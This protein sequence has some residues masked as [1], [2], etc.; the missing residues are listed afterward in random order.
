MDPAIL[1]HYHIFKNAGTSV[2]A[3]LRRHFGNRWAAFEGAHAHDVKSSSELRAFLDANP[4]VRAVSSHLARPPLPT[5]GSVPIVFLRHPLLRARSV[6]EFTR[7]DAAQPFREAT[8]GSFADYLRWAL[9]G[10]QGGVVVRDYQ[11][12]HLSSASFC[13]E[14]ILAANATETQLREAIALLDRW[15]VIGVVERY[16]QSLRLME[17]AYADLFPGLVLRAE[18]LNRAAEPTDEAALGRELGEDLLRQFQSRNRLDYGLYEYAL[19]RLA[20]LSRQHGL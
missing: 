18:H 19:Q 11:V 7:R 9:S 13:A 8:S 10:A 2:D 1:V 4:H 5:R 14:G 17:R 6:Y 16:E 15:P 12:I 20:V 3:A